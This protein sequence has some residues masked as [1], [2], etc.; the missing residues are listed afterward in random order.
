MASK[1]VINLAKFLGRAADPANALQSAIQFSTVGGVAAYK[2]PNLPY[3][4][5]ALEPVINGEIM[6]LHH[7]KHHATYV[8]NLNK[9]LEQYAEAESKRDLPKVISLQSAINF[10]GGGHIN[11]DIFW[12]NLAPEKDAAPPSGELLDAINAK[13]G[14]LDNF[15]SS[16]NTTTAAVQGSGWGWLAYHKGNKALE[17]VTT[18]NQDPVAAKGY[19]PLLG[20]DVWEHAYY[21][22]YKNVRP[23]YLKNIWRVINWDNV[24]QRYAEA[25]V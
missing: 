7:S 20:V 1:G 18:A 24:A 10:N 13:W 5:D 15:R 21:L 6:E 9:A 23:D 25:K 3:S 17:I 19:V 14:S 8:T 4:Y 16:F 12:T 2:L 22:Q 11:H